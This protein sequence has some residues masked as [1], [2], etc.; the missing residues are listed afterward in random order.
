LLRLGPKFDWGIRQPLRS[1][2]PACLLVFLVFLCSSHCSW[3]RVKQTSRVPVSEQALP[4]KTANLEDLA[5]LVNDAAQD[6]QS[7]KLTVIYQLTGG[8]INTGQISNYRETDGFILLK[9]P[10]QI[11]LIG[12]AFKVTVFDMASDGKEF[13]IYVPPKNKFIHGLNNQEIRSRPDIPVNLRPQHIFQALAIQP[14]ALQR[15]RHFL[16]LEEDQEGKRKYYILNVVTRGDRS[17]AL[18]RKIWIDRFDLSL[19]RQK[20]FDAD[21]KVLSDIA[22]SD[23]RDFDGGRY[24]GIIDFRRPQEDYSLRIR[25]SKGT[26][27]DSLRPEQFV[28]EQPPGT[29]LIDLARSS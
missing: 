20:M 21:G 8:S 18:Q 15:D 10:E 17:I 16:F 22:Y 2:K 25:V 23:L 9:K 13:R 11:R 24:P 3:F 29:E 5:R 28:L 19:T 1:K 27:N 4:A 26:I 6:V 7:L 12:Q 14:L